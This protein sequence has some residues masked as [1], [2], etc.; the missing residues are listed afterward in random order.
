MKR[1]S[2]LP[3][4]ALS[5]SSFVA[6]QKTPRTAHYFDAPTFF[7]YLLIVLSMLPVYLFL[8]FVFRCAGLERTYADYI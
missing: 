7:S 5:E 1:T 6:V 4:L 2:A 3:T 8:I